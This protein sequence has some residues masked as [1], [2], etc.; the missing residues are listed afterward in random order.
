[1]DIY[2]IYIFSEK[3]VSE[4][5]CEVIIIFFLIV[6]LNLLYDIIEHTA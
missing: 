2:I 4:V 3:I 6:E 5:S 1:M